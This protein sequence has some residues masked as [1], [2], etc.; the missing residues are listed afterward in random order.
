MPTLTGKFLSLTITNSYEMEK[1]DKVHTT[2]QFLG[3]HAFVVMAALEE[4]PLEDNSK[5]YDE[6]RTAFIKSMEKMI[7]DVTPFTEHQEIIYCRW[8]IYCESIAQAKEA[9][10]LV[11]SDKLK[12][13]AIKRIFYLI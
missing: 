5:S 11:W 9:H 10:D 6:A 3:I 1:L 8:L 2:A 13:I 12:F 7:I 4:V